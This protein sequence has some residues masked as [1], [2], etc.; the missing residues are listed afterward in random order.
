LHQFA[1]ADRGRCE[2]QRRKLVSGAPPFG[3]CV[4]DAGAGHRAALEAKSDESTGRYLSYY[5]DDLVVV[6]WDAAVD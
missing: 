1:V 2:S 5:E 4:A 6:D 3:G